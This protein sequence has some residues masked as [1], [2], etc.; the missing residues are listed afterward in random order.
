MTMTL[1]WYQKRK[2]NRKPAIMK[3]KKLSVMTILVTKIFYNSKS[4]NN[5][6]KTKPVEYFID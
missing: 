1:L 2:V 5:H 4:S 6:P 3:R